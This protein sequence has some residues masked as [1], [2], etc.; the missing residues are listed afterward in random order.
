M[1]SLLLMAP[2]TNTISPWKI[3]SFSKMEL[4]TKFPIRTIYLHP[5]IH[6]L[7]HLPWHDLDRHPFLL[8]ISRCKNNPWTWLCLS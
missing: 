2:S 7:I 8:S 6:Q 3:Q 1:L 4:H 5:P